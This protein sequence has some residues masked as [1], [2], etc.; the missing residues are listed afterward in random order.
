LTTLAIDAGGG[1]VRLTGGGMI[2]PKN[3]A[4]HWNDRRSPEV[5]LAQHS[6]TFSSSL[7][8]TVFV[9]M[10]G[11]FWK[12]EETA[13]SAKQQNPSHLHFWRCLWISRYWIMSPLL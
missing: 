11:C 5:D 8:V 1:E 4:A 10:R 13:H 7:G 9:T 3:A 12:S 6:E 2:R